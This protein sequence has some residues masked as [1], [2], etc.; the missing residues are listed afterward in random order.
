MGFHYLLKQYAFSAK[1]KTC[2]TSHVGCYKLAT[3]YNSIELI[4]AVHFSSGFALSLD[5]TQL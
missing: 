1:L 4:R 2:T 5:K 3:R